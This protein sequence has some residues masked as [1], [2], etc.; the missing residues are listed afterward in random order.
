MN[1]FGIQRERINKIQSPLPIC[2]T[3]PCYFE[4][5]FQSSFMSKTFLILHRVSLFVLIYLI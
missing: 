5:I 4:F 1:K 2:L 3:K